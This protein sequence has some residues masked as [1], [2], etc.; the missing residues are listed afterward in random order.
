MHTAE[1]EDIIYEWENLKD[2]F[3][4]EIKTCKK[5][6]DSEKLNCTTVEV[7][8]KNLSIVCWASNVKPGIKVPVALV[9]AKLK[10]DFVIS[11]V[12]IRW[13]ISEWMICSAD[14]LWLAKEKQEW[15]LELPKNAPLNMNF[16]EYLQKNDII[17]EI[18]N[19]AINH[20]PDLFSHIWIA[21]E[22]EAID[23]K[24]LEYQYI[25]KDFSKLPSL[26]II[27]EIPDVVSRY[28]LLKVENV[29]N[30]ESPDYI[31]AV[32]W[33]AWVISKWLLVDVSNYSL[34]LYWQPIHCFDAD[35]IEWQFRA[36]F[37]KKWEKFLALDWKTYELSNE[38]IV[39]AD[40]KKIL[41]LG[42]IMWWLESSVSDTTKSI[43]IESAHFNQAILRMT[44]K[45]LG[46]RTDSL[47]LFEKD[48][49]EELQIYWLS[50][51]VGELEKNLN[52]IKL[53]AYSD[54]YPK[55]QEKVEVDFDLNFINKLIWKE[56]KKEETL[57]IL[58]NLW[59]ELVWN[60]LLIPFWRKDL[61]YKA[62]IAEEI[63]R[64][65]WFDNIKATLPQI[66]SGAITQSNVY[67]IK[68]DARK[69]FTNIWYFDLYTYSFVNEE[70]M[71]K[72]LS[73]T[74]N[75]VPMKNA[76]SEELTHLRWSLLPNLLLAL[77][78]NEKNFSNLKLFEL[79]KVFIMEKNDVIEYY[80]L[81]WV[82]TLNTE[83]IYYTIQNT[84]SN[85]LK[86]VWV[87][88]FQY[89]IP[90]NLPNYTHPSRTANIIVR[91][92]NI[93]IIGEIHPKVWDNFWIGHKIWFFEINVNKLENALYQTIKAKDISNFQ[94][95]EFDLNFVVD[96][97]TKASKIKKI[98]E[99]TSQIIT[100]VELTDIYE[101]KDKLPWK[102]SLTYKI[103]IQSMEKTL[104][105]NDKWELIKEIIEN[106]K[107]V[108]GELRS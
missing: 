32:I 90:E 89:D 15:I 61:H 6:P 46:I 5:H 88:D 62:D 91:W 100:K 20:R 72:C 48:I 99:K 27:N 56:F 93:W 80:S 107:K 60:K 29:A 30:V 49:V 34:Y 43:L 70:L 18:D 21:R 13:E 84:I 31:K 81:A 67:K 26:W 103:Y 86:S 12:K 22:I 74:K 75:L 71:Q 66:E 14:E 77:E 38:D 97:N 94:E 65:I 39:L 24:K 45:R 55:K 52:W 47:N 3:I 35:K 16:R 98:I 105:D 59:I 10:D 28:S 11:K 85:F 40:D 19:K 42:W 92:Q 82:E 79:E 63:A 37:A 1:V 83:K 25:I 36:R 4:W 51:V 96:K 108:G 58:S 69:F 8:G 106:V 7:N 54:I 53:I 33:S 104:D 87:Y 50:L 17:F 44:G 95:N 68:N 78:K 64:I 23:W 41:C 76:L 102:R 101:N 9:W 57:K 2:V 73:N